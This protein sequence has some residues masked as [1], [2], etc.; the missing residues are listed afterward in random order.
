MQQVYR[1]I[2]KVAPI[3]DPVLILGETG[4]GKELI[5][6]ALHEFGRAG[7]PWVPF[8]I[9]AGTSGLISSDL[10]GHKAGSFTGA[11][12]ARKGLLAEAGAGTVLLD[13]IGD[14]DAPSQVK[15][16]RVIEER[17]F[18]RVGGNRPEALK[19]RLVFATHKDLDEL[20]AEGLFREDLLERIGAFTITAPPLRDRTEDL[21]MLAHHFLEEFEDEHGGARQLPS[22]TLD[23]LFRHT[24][25]RNVRELRNVIRRSA[26]YSN[27]EEGPV[28]PGMIR[29]A[30]RRRTAP[31]SPG[32]LSFDPSQE[33][34]KNVE[35][36]VKRA[37][38]ERVFEMSGRNVVSAAT[39]AGIGTTTF[40]DLLKDLEI[41]K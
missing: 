22:T 15:L 3:A 17:Q 29:Q 35:Q 28:H 25:P 16:L 1:D 37:Y 27:N 32:L 7:L 34:W 30:T 20:V 2:E 9:A 4:T 21:S 10:F 26:T 18:R 39:M 38:F 36:R 33:T 31:A 41:R 24:W 40:Y 23:L 5:G 14:L 8:N 12:Q 11:A 19:A 6:R 13:E